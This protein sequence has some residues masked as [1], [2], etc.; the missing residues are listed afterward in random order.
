[1]KSR[2]PWEGV[3]DAYDPAY[4]KVF[5]AAFATGIEAAEELADEDLERLSAYS[6]MVGI[7]AQHVLQTRR[8]RGASEVS[9]RSR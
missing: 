1:M 3:A 6:G 8:T 9:S 7:V 5:D 4:L 2:A